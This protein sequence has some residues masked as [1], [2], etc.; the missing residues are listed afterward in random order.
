MPKWNDT[1]KSNVVAEL[2]RLADKLHL[3]P[4]ETGEDNVLPTAVVSGLTGPY[5]VEPIV[6]RVV[7]YEEDVCVDVRNVCFAGS[8]GATTNRAVSYIMRQLFNP[9]DDDS[10]GRDQLGLCGVLA[11]LFRG[12]NRTTDDL[13][14]MIVAASNDHVPKS[15]AA[16]DFADGEVFVD[17]FVPCNY[18]T[19]PDEFESVVRRELGHASWIQRTV[20]I[21]RDL[22]SPDQVPAP[23]TVAKLFERLHAAKKAEEARSTDQEPV[24]EFTL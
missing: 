11:D 15:A 17:T 3:E 2:N 20:R 21:V 12:A 14:V 1:F 18:E 9:D 5:A 6:L 16:V 7:G 8:H 13:V 4:A 19:L 24:E 10:L 22:L 23:R